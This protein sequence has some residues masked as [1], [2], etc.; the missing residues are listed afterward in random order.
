MTTRANSRISGAAG[1]AGALITALAGILHPKGS[2]DVGTVREW[3]TRVA[4]SELWIFVHLTLMI[5]GILVLIATIGIA[6]SFP[7]D[8]AS[9]W[10]GI[11]VIAN[12][13]ATAIAVTTFLFD[14]AVVKRIA[15][16]WQARPNDP[17]TVGAAR[18]ATE[19]GFILVA[20]LQ[21]MTG[22]VALLF[23]C[24]GVMSKA[25]PKWLAWLALAAGITGVVP[26]AAHYLL[27]ASTWSVTLVYVSGGLFTIWTFA[28]SLRIWMRVPPVSPT[29][30][31]QVPVAARI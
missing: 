28:M 29:Q 31:G 30:Q 2:S 24:A 18:L 13:V 14:G 21:L 1:L 11:A 27:G 5:G 23:G 12:V 19:T 17:A 22:M 26:G 20:G 8:A 4:G 10:A 25:H 6:R 15:E 9:A 3:M 16:L 7:E